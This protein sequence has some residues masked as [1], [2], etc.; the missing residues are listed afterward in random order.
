ML[1]VITND[2]LSSELSAVGIEVD[3]HGYPKMSKL[4]SCVGRRFTP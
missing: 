4:P 2:Q 1:P 3:G